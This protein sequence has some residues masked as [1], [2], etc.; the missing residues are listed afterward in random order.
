MTYKPP[1]RPPGD[2]SHLER[3]VQELSVDEGIAADRLRSW[4]STQILLGALGRVDGD[5]TR[6]LLKGGAA[7]RT[8]PTHRRSAWT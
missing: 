5:S 3:L 6:F 2:R 8:S 4:V 7:Y 1:R